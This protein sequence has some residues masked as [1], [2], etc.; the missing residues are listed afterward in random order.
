MG[1]L[2]PGAVPLHGDGPIVSR[3]PATGQ[4][5]GEVP[6]ATADDARHEEL[7]RQEGATHVA[8]PHAL[9]AAFLSK[10]VLPAVGE[11]SK[12]ET[13]AQPLATAAH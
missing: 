8:S 6:V 4:V 10:V 1:A 12:S 11:E 13:H 9:Q 7:L 3:N 5:L 2:S